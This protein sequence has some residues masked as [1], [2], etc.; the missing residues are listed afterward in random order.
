M[1]RPKMH[2]DPTM[3][4]LSITFG[5]S[6]R[7]R[8]ITSEIAPG[9]HADY[10]GAQLIAIEVL[11]ASMHVS[12][13]VLANIEPPTEWLTIAEAVAESRR[14]PTTLRNAIAAGKLEAEKRGRDWMVTRSSL[15]N[16]LEAL[17]PAGR[18]PTD[19]RAPYRVRKALR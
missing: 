5:R 16:Y 8:P 15:W 3:D 17:R 12:P 9:I 11:D 19:R 10:I 6:A 2:Y 14:R 7:G 1:P 18:K 13:K 4:A